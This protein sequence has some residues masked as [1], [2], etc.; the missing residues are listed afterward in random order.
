MSPI[1]LSIFVVASTFGQAT[2]AHVDEVHDRDIRASIRK[3]GT[4]DYAAREEAYRELRRHGLAAQAALRKAMRSEDGETRVRATRLVRDIEY[5][6]LPGTDV[7]TK[8]LTRGFRDGLPNER[9]AAFQSL[10]ELERIEILERLIRLEAD[11]LVRRQLLAQLFQSKN[12]VDRFIE[13]D[14]IDALIAA[15]GADQNTQWRRSVTILLMFSPTMLARLAERGSLGTLLQ[16]I[17]EETDARARNAMLVAIFRTPGVGFVLAQNELTFVLDT[18][19]A[20]P[21]RNIR[22][23]LLREIFSNT[24]AAQAIVANKQ[25][26]GILNFSREHTSAASQQKL[27]ERMLASGPVVES[28]LKDG[29]VDRVIALVAKEPDS[30]MRGRLLGATISSSAV[31]TFLQRNGLSDLAI[32]LAKD[33]TNEAARHE[34][35]QALLHD[36]SFVYSLN[37]EATVGELWQ[38]IKADKNVGWRAQALIVLLQSHR[39]NALLKDKD[40]AVWILKLASDDA[41]GPVRED[42]LRFLLPNVQAQR[43]LIANGYFDTMLSLARHLPL[44]SRGEI[45]ANFLSGS[46]VGEHLVAKQKLEL[47]I[48]VPNEETDAGVKQLCLQGI[49]RNGI[50]MTALLEAGH[51]VTFR[52]MIQNET[53]PARRASLF[54]AFVQNYRVMQRLDEQGDSKLLLAYAEMKDEGARR[55]F[56]PRLFQNHQAVTLLMKEGHFDRLVVLAKQDGGRSFD[57]FLAVPEVIEH[58][59][60]TNQFA[61]FLDFASKDADDNTR[62]SLFRNVFINSRTVEALIASENFDRLLQ[63]I[64]A[65]RDTTWRGSLLGPVVSSSP[66]VAHFAKQN[67]LDALLSLISSDPDPAVRTRLLTYLASRSDVLTTFIEHGNLDVLMALVNRQ[68]VGR[69]RGD[70][71]ARIVTN[72]KALEQ[73]NADQRI[74]LLL[75]F[76]GD[77]DPEFVSAYVSRLFVT[78]RATD[79]LVETGYY[80]DVFKI[81]TTHRDA[82]LR[83]ALIGRLLYSQNA[84]DQMIARNDVAKLVS[85]VKNEP[86]VS[87]RR[88]YLTAVCSNERLVDA[89]LKTELFASLVDTLHSESDAAAK[90]R[91]LATLTYSV[92][93]VARLAA[94]G[95]LDQI[96]NDA[97]A[98]SDQK[99][100]ET[101]LRT[102]IQRASTFEALVKLNYGE[103][104]LDATEDRLSVSRQQSLLRT[105]FSNQNAVRTLLAQG[106]FERLLE[107]SKRHGGSQLG[108]LLRSPVIIDHLADAKKIALVLQYAAEELEPSAKYQVL[109]SLAM[110]TKART[111]L[112]AIG[113]FE[114][115]YASVQTVPNVRQRA[116]LLAAVFSSS[117]FARHFVDAQTVDPLFAFIERNATI[118]ANSQI[119]ASVISSNQ[120]IDVLIEHGHFEALLRI[121]NEQT[122]GETKE[123]LLAQLRTSP[124]VLEKLVADEEG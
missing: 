79:L 81:A 69:G 36:T 109:Y 14:R 41:A 121:T 32:K 94:D 90:R 22:G 7:T 62:R 98:E 11:P 113:Q 93:A 21:D 59:A 117:E 76:A 20:E 89:L 107:S 17:R 110:S 4:S 38:L 47:F 15:V 57:E 67:K 33:E 3:L 51:Y 83:T 8:R 56:L 49:F 66:I 99:F 64:R 1:F 63:L 9:L 31:R 28:L 16:M 25:L 46:G 86:D 71:L 96:V 48:E 18:L 112:L 103:R 2:A 19:R 92:K 39:S 108:N 40:E 10:V 85:I 115:F 77:A 75:S 45:L 61:L 6:I 105:I 24:Q 29:G 74:G 123:R 65:E 73:L 87:L 58:L 120:A 44:R 26:D 42:I 54:G 27:I 106:H 111:S 119:L 37:N 95:Q 88:N 68:V 118:V 91:L 82:R 114:S 97:I 72:T 104:L 124:K 34:F 53:D 116:P 60:A 35:L 52:D 122:K 30:V 13:R 43:V 78:T 50:A 102:I 5:G 55:Q 23:E 12:I 101:W 84:I 100:R 80:S 70:L